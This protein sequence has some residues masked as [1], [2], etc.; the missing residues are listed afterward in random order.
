MSYNPQQVEMFSGFLSIVGAQSSTKVKNCLGQPKK[1]DQGKDNGRS[2][3]HILAVG[4]NQSGDHPHQADD[5][6]IDDHPAEHLGEMIGNGL[7]YSQ[8]GNQQDDAYYLNVHY[9]GQGHQADQ[10]AFHQAHRYAE[11]MGIALI[12]RDIKDD[13]VKKEEKHHDHPGKQAHKQQVTLG[14]S[15]DAAKKVC[16]QVG[17]IARGQIDKYDA[18]GHPKRPPYP[19]DRIMPQLSFLGKK[20]YPQGRKHTEN[21][22]SPNGVDP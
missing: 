18:D 12:K 5:H 7:G 4:K 1:D 6:R 3:R 2:R 15:E 22:R 17:R 11:N 19:Y 14:Y 21:C 13:P 20:L 10:K 16:H 8:K 9:N